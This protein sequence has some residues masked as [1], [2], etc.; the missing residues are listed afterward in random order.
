[1]GGILPRVEGPGLAKHGPLSKLA[2]NIPSPS[3]LHNSASVPALTSLKDE[4]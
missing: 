1:M 2:S 3:L 4:L